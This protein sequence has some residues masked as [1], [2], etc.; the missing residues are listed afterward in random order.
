MSNKKT[1]EYVDK[2]FNEVDEAFATVNEAFRI[3]N[4]AFRTANRAFDSVEVPFDMKET[5]FTDKTPPKQFKNARV[6]PLTWR[7]RLK[8]IKLAFCTAK[9]V[10]M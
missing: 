5:K 7:N 2:A 6:I 8:M 1:D 4:E 10:R 9:S 3:A